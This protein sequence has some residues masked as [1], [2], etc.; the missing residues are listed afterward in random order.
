ML[1][2]TQLKAQH[3]LWNLTSQMLWYVVFFVSFFCLFHSCSLPVLWNC[4]KA[5]NSFHLF[6]LTMWVSNL[7]LHS[8]NSMDLVLMWKQMEKQN[9]SADSLGKCKDL[10]YFFLTCMIAGRIYLELDHRLNKKINI[11]WS[12]HS[13]KAEISIVP[14]N[15]WTWTWLELLWKRKLPNQSNNTC[16]INS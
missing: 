12:L 16:S 1:S 3:R 15:S 8:W 4:S 9:G 13:R 14:Y 11:N 7:K 5:L 2:V 6:Q 10:L